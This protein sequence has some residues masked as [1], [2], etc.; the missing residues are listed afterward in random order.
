MRL[1]RALL[2]FYPASF[3]AEYGDEMEAVFRARRR[4]ATNPPAVFLLWIEAFFEIVFNAVA[5][6]WDILRQDLRYTARTLARSPGF[7]VTAILVVA[8]G[9]G[10]NTAAFSV[11]DFVLIRNLPFPEPDRLVK[12]WQTESG[13]D[14]MEFSPLNYRDVKRM[15]KSFEAMG[16]YTPD[17]VNLVG[18]GDPQRIDSVAVTSEVIPVLGTQ[19]LLGRV[20]TSLDEREGAPGTVLLSYQ[21]WQAQFGGDPGVLGRKVILDDRPYVVIGV[22]P[23]HFNFPSAGVGLWVPKQFKAQEFQ[24]RDDNYLDVVGRLKPGVSLK[25]A[26]AE[27]D[28]TMQQ[29]KREY[30]GENKNTGGTVISLRDE[31]SDKSRLM[32]WALLGASACVLLIACANLANLLLTRSLGRQKELAVRAALGAGR[33]RLVRQ[34]MTESM[35]L[36]ALGG[37]LG[38]FVAIGAV[39]LL[40]KL[41]P[42]E[43]PIA[44]TPAVDFRV[45]I[46]AGLLTVVTG[47]VFG[48]LPAFRASGKGDMNA[49]REGARSGGGR[50]ERLRAALVIAEVTVSVVLL[51]SSG[52]L[53]RALWKLQ[54]T[55]PGF[56]AGGVLTVQTA[57]PMP[58][59]QR[60]ARRVEF[61]DRVLTEVRALPGVSSASYSTS[62]PM[63]WGGGIWPVDINGQVV[64]RTASH[65]VSMRYITPDYFATLQIPLLLGRG[66]SE[67]DAA[68]GQFVAVVSQSFVRR[69]W[70]DQNPLGHHFQMAFHDRMVVG[71]VGDVRVRGLEGEPSEPQAYFSYRQVV[72]GNL[73]YYAPQDLAVRSSAT[74]ESLVP[75]I[76]R[77]IQS[78]DREQPISNVRTMEQIVE[79][80]T[81]SRT[82]QVRVLGAFAGIAFLL[83]A[84]GIH[85]LLS[86]AVSQRNREIGVRMALGAAS[87][88]ILRM[89]LGQGAWVAMAGVAPGL[90][91]AYVA[92]RLMQALLAGVQPGDLATFFSAAGLCLVMTL[93]GSF[94]PALRA[95]RIDPMTAIR[96]E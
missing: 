74:P 66:V 20:F 6:H 84:I 41:V 59:Y 30:P 87:G 1:Y 27:M 83:A 29:L 86:F 12:I 13:Y 76:R 2:H 90:V 32:L 24:D 47:V 89:V 92:A 57:L 28:V 96:T 35:V 72:D 85:G 67:S 15:S 51:I 91:L 52:L 45:L 60:T 46:F 70:P 93:V 69:Y 3:R 61:Y 10:A 94:L 17:A 58:K 31:L 7:A 64:E 19:P 11:T 26:E 42:N 62:L 43:L 53:I 34:S 21:L 48:V 75:A 5:V 78:A 82:V 40:A 55:D 95:V 50:K 9:I 16:A 80:K 14:Q 63:V 22:M 36:A 88:D 49:L 23:S 44:S 54:G 25:Q 81:A 56:H 65:T 39:P 4:D 8:L 73:V 71:V 33:E 68:D 18:Q 77:I 37:A 79:L 38:I